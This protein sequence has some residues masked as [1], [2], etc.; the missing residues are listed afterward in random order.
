MQVTLSRSPVAP[1]TGKMQAQTWGPEP[2]FAQDA[3]AD[4][5]VTLVSCPRCM[6]ACCKSLAC[7]DIDLAQLERSVA[8]AEGTSNTRA[9][10]ARTPSCMDVLTAT[11]PVAALRLNSLRAR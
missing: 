9:G 7:R 2:G 8:D 10:V 11:H 3:H 1:V 4:P 5:L 6:K